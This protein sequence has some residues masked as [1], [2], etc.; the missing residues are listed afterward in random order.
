M[1]APIII[2]AG[3]TGGH[4]FPAEALADCLLKRGHNL[5]LM[6]DER[7]THRAIGAFATSPQYVL[8]GSG[9]A[10]KGLKDKLR[11]IFSLLKGTIGARTLVKAIHPAAIIGFGGYPSIPPLLG[12][13]L[14]PRRRRPV[15][16]IHEGNAVLGK[17]N[18]LIAR[19]ATAIA[20]SYADVARLPPGSAVTLTGMPVRAEIEAL[21]ASPYSPPENE[22]ESPLELLIWGGSLGAQIFSQVVPDALIALPDSIR[23]RLHITQQL[24]SELIPAIQT[25]YDKAGIRADLLPFIKD[26]ASVLGKAH[27]VIGR[28]GGSSVAELTM[29]GKPAIMVP[30]PI[31]ASDEQGAN[32]KALEE[33]GAGWMIRQK[34]FTKENLANRL[35]DLFTYPE[36]LVRA[37]QASA[38]LR[39]Q[40]AAEKL[41][42][43]IEKYLP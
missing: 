4:F 1:K 42:D 43:L 24:K 39:H 9:V 31:A 11:G 35:T 40:K 33:A 32:A 28:A 20:T 10:G 5:I 26:V 36:Q 12:G 41:A 30:L 21:A 19:F 17:A 15:L 23:K 8:S 37:A 34:D 13:A 25:R 6:T 14:F 29:A 22:G 2:A 38:T 16:I 3:G 7:N 18:A 27:L